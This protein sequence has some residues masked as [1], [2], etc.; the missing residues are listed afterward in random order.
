MP[1][2]YFSLLITCIVMSIAICICLRIKLLEKN[3][4]QAAKTELFDYGILRI[5]LNGALTF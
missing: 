4:K 1:G 5:S 2:Y 3:N